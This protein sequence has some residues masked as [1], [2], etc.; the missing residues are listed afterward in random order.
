MK[1]PIEQFEFTL[2][3]ATSGSDDKKSTARPWTCDLC[4]L[5]NPATALEQC[6]VCE[7][8]KPAAEP[9]PTVSSSQIQKSSGGGGGGGGF[10]WSAATGGQKSGE[11]RDSGSKW[12]CGTCMLQNPESEK[13][14]CGVCETPRG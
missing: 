13:E 10:D 8:P 4:M 5:S 6:V 14:K 12:T 3:V 9:L 1:R 11:N 2:D 7:A